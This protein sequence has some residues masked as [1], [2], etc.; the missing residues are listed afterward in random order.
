V[1]GLPADGRLDLLGRGRAV[2]RGPD[3]RFD[4][5]ILPA[6][7][8]SADRPGDWAAS[9]WLEV[10]VDGWRLEVTVEPAAR[11]DLRDRARRSGSAQIPI[12]AAEVRAIIPGRVAAVAVAPGDAVAAGQALVILEAMKMQN[13]LRA[14]RAGTV[15]RVAVAAGDTVDAGALLL[16]IE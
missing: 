12:P 9:S 14:P 2:F 8:G 5:L 7:A 6:A 4:V 13:E 1:N 15:G 10:V 11:A 16:V 3:G